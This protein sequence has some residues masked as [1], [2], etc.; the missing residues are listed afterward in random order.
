[1]SSLE[2]KGRAR[3]ASVQHGG[4]SRLLSACDGQLINGLDLDPHARVSAPVGLYNSVSNWT[5]NNY[6]VLEKTYEVEASMT[7]GLGRP[8]PG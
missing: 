4:E 7:P 5:R 6:P 2:G 3:L 1:M 8:W